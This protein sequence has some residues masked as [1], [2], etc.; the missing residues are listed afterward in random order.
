LEI[1]AIEVDPL[2]AFTGAT[3]AITA[4]LG[5]YAL[6]LSRRTENKTAS[7]EEINTVLTAQSGLLDRYEGRI[8]E[9]EV[10]IRNNEAERTAL[11]HAMRNVEQSHEDCTRR[12]VK[13][14]VQIQYLQEKL[15]GPGT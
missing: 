1:F 2:A 9:C 4:F 5:T 7:R 13:A 3:A 14:E 10:E 11:R 6:V 8:K 15:D 12:L